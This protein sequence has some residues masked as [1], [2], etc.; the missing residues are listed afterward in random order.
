MKLAVE[1]V[2]SMMSEFFSTYFF[3]DSKVEYVS[4]VSSTILVLDSML[5]IRSFSTFYV[6]RS[7]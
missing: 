6:T 1:F 5:L 3:L 2:A 7:I 4:N